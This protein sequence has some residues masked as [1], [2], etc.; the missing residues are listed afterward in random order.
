M[1]SGYVFSLRDGRRIQRIGNKAKNLQFLAQ[2]GFSIPLTH[3]CTWDT[4]VR[5]VHGDT[6]VI[7]DLRAQLEAK[8][9]RQ[10]RY[11]VRSSA[12]LEDGQDLSFAGQFK[13]VLDVQGWKKF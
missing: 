13:S 6:Q 2:R 7:E 9:D 10:K 8:L 11:A 4:Y 3:V 5:Y 1:P 12:N